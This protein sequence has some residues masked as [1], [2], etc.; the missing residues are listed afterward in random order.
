MQIKSR[1]GVNGSRPAGTLKRGP[2]SVNFT[3]MVRASPRRINEQLDK[4]CEYVNFSFCHEEIL[5]FTTRSVLGV[6][7]SPL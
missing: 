6:L 5:R 4:M 1:G 2:V 7:F 3:V